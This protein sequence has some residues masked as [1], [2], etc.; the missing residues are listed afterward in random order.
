MKDIDVLIDPPAFCAG[1]AA[2]VRWLEGLRK[3][4]PEIPAIA[5]AIREAEEVVRYYEAEE[6]QAA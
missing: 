1:K 6:K 4:D 2:W 3:D 5:D